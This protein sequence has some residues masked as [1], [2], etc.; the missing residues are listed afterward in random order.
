L[1]YREREMKNLVSDFD[2]AIKY[3]LPEEKIS[4]K[5]K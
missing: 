3:L 2:R 5:K 4:K 1:I